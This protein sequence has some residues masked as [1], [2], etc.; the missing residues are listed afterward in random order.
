M[1]RVR[2][3]SRVLAVL[4]DPVAHSISPEMHNAAIAALGLNAVYVA[5]RVPPPALPVALDTCAALELA[6]NL[7]VPHKAAAVASI[8]VLSPLAARLGA[9]NTFWTEAGVLHGDNTDVAGLGD[10]LAHLDAPAPWLLKGTG[11]S[12]R[13]VVAAAAAMGVPVLV[14][15]RSSDRA[16]AFCAWARDYDATL[17][18]AADDGRSVGTALNATPLGLGAGDP[19]P[20]GA[21]RLSG[22]RVALDLVYRPGETAWVRDCRARGLVAADGRELLLAQGAHAFERFFP[23]Q[24]A[25]REQMRAAVRRALSG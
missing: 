2:G 13:A 16:Q 6:G 15:S 9:V 10:V 8:G 24:R 18:I 7:T 19:A 21:D 25:P 11:G 22:T 4:G 20:L 12:A 5:L 23:G 3:T 1:L 17:E 14:A